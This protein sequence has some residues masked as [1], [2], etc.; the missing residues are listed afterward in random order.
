VS[1][2]CPG[3]KAPAGGPGDEAYETLCMGNMI[4][5]TITQT[6]CYDSLVTGHFTYETLCLLESS[7]TGFHIVYA[8]IMSSKNYVIT[9]DMT[10]V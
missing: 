2:W 9:I 1:H 4:Q 6:D 10:A 3:A 5:H 8:L 7:S